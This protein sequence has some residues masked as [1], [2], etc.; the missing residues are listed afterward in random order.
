MP[1]LLDGQGAWDGEGHGKKQVRG[2]LQGPCP[3]WAVRDLRMA[4]AFG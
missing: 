4:A 1:S 3:F 2:C